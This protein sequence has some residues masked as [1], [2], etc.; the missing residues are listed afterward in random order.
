MFWYTAKQDR[1]EEIYNMRKNKV[2]VVLI[3]P[4]DKKNIYGSL[5]G[6]YTAVDPPWWL[7]AV[8]GSLRDNGLCVK[9]IDADA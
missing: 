3:K 9:V 8:G 2:D 6:K 5:Q 7:A 1:T 4:N